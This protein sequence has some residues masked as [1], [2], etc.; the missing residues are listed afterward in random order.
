MSKKPLDPQDPVNQD[1][2]QFYTQRGAQFIA[3]KHGLAPRTICTRAKALGVRSQKDMPDGFPE[4]C[5]A[6]YPDEGAVKLAEDFN[7]S[8]SQVQGYAKRHKI[9]ASPEARSKALSAGQIGPREQEI[10]DTVRAQYIQEGP[11]KL[12]EEL[13]MT[14]GAVM[15]LASRL[16]L[17][18]RGAGNPSPIAPQAEKIKKK[19]GA[20]MRVNPDL[21]EAYRWM[22]P[23][24]GLLGT[25][26]LFGIQNSTLWYRCRKLGIETTIKNHRMGNRDIQLIAEQSRSRS[27]ASIAK[28][29]GFDPEAVRQHRLNMGLESPGAKVLRLNQDIMDHDYFTRWSPEM[30]YDL[31]NGFADACVAVSTQT[32]KLSG[33][34]LQV[35][36]KDEDLIVQTRDRIKSFHKLTRFDYRQPTGKT[37]H[38]VRCFITS[39]VLAESLVELH[40]MHPRK[41][42][43]DDPLPEVPDELFR[44]FVRGYLDGDGCVGCWRYPG[45]IRR[46]CYILGNKTF[47]SGLRDR[48]VAQ[49]GV[50]GGSWGEAPNTRPGTLYRVSWQSYDD[51]EKLFRYLYYRPEIP[52]LER[53]LAGF[54]VALSHDPVTRLEGPDMA[55]VARHFCLA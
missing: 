37:G 21:V 25:A 27:D 22:L 10:R 53:K 24:Y 50:S 20:K 19:P 46:T 55:L 38:A 35:C 32:K 43:R 3:E 44:D 51:I 34:R 15:S 8:I 49:A 13:G 33:Y 40:G 16:G 45:Q 7:L 2:I 11:A 18:R 52:C 30:A 5:R 42:W 17:K 28:E 54:N 48:V 26:N 41:T 1:I 31:G 23:L 9:K 47:L 12:A 36:T 29:L 39:K 6:R 4:A 14:E